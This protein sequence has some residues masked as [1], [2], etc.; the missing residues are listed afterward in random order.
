[1]KLL[2]AIVRDLL[3]VIFIIG[4]AWL[5]L[6]VYIGRKIGVA[7]SAAEGFQQLIAAD[8]N[9]QQVTEYLS[10]YRTHQTNEGTLVFLSPNIY[11]LPRPNECWNDRL[12]NSLLTGLLQQGMIRLANSVGFSCYRLVV[13]AGVDREGKLAGYLDYFPMLGREVFLW[14][15][16]ANTKTTRNAPYAV[17]ETDRWGSAIV[18]VYPNTPQP[19]SSALS[20]IDVRCFR[21]FSGCSFQ[22]ILPAAAAQREH[23][24]KRGVDPCY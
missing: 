11:L 20:A 4:I 13:H 6:R 18:R 23:D 16:L 21:K 9:R 2:R 3:V 24:L 22:E 7:Q 12:Q 14:A 15:N 1:M 8:A 17:C 10:K 19:I 5:G